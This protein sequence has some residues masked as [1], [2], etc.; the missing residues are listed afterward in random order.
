MRG[1]SAMMLLPL[2]ITSAVFTILPFL[3]DHKMSNIYE[4]IATIGS[5]TLQCGIDRT[6]NM[7][8]INCVFLVHTSQYT[9][10]NN[11]SN[12]YDTHIS[13]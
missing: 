12:F 6:A 5:A 3:L 4:F 11:R 8:K 9:N 7:W 13:G 2:I 10:S 1:A